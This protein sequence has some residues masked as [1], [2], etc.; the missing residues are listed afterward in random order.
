MDAINDTLILESFLTYVLRAYF[1]EA[2]DAAVAA[3]YVPL[4]EL[5][6][7]VSLQTQMGQMLDLLSQPQGRKDSSLLPSFTIDRYKAVVTVRYY[8]QFDMYV[9]VDINICVIHYSTRRRFIP[10]TCPWRAASSC[11]ALRI[12]AR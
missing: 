4:M 8:F 3:S 1:K 2:S 7:D 6:Q 12:R 5:F 11:R 9:F 10:F